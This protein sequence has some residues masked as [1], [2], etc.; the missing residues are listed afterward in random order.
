M[1]F[2]E[3]LRKKNINPKDEIL[4]GL[5][6]ALALVPEAVAFSLIA[7]VSPLLGLY[8]AFIIGLITAILG[9]RPG[10]IS[11]ATGAIAVVIVSL[12]A[13]HGVE[14]LFA[15]VIL[16]GAIQIL[17][18]GLKLGKFIR[19]V[20]H[21]VIFGFVN[22][23]AIVIFMSQLNEFK[24]RDA[25]GGM[26]WLSGTPLYIMLGFVFLTMII[27]Y[28]LPKLT[29]AVPSS[30]VAILLVSAVIIGFGIETKSVGDIASIAGGLPEF[31]IPSIPFTV[32]T[33]RIIFPYSVIMALVGL[34]ESLLTLT[35]VDEMTETRGRGN[36][37]CVAQGVANVTTGF[38]GGMGGC[39]MIGQSIIN[40]SSGG[41][42][43]I[44]STV[45]AVALLAF[46]LFGSSL[47]ERVPM[48]ALVGLMI[49]VAIGTFEWASLKV[50]RKVPKTDI[51][52]MIL[53]TLVTAIFHNLAVAVIS[54]VVIS[55]LAFAWES[56]V[57]IRAR[58]FT[59]QNNIRHY[60][61][62]GPLFFGSVTAFG[63]K[64]DV[65]NDPDEVIIDFKESRVV[66]HSAI[67]ALNKIT[68]RYRKLGKKVHLR[69]LSE[70]CRL[71]LN[72]AAEIIDVNYWEDPHYK[73]LVDKLEG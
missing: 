13:S 3:Q 27:I 39:A 1:T 52:V 43:R 70:D 60:E 5:T 6:V 14:Y 10:M 37:E 73:V 21:P 62:F 8:A 47:I 34:I 12:V 68:E 17:I 65:H 22:G 35:V 16:M 49:M 31:H 20:P 53:V 50:F 32:E 42:T 25:S 71:L 56:A 64:F 26:H 41:R 55:A 2:V 66:D 24:Y 7:N 46:V 67:D 45:A 58:K 28:F 29:K 59:D 61:I 54:G 72:N 44:S 36:K 11:G 63:E 40:V 51:I 23:L 57:R 30:L 4:S 18:G 33:F 15:A 38:F 69:H 19:L 48:A 9:G